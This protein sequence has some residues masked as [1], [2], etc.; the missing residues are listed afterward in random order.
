MKKLKKYIIVGQLLILL[1]VVFVVVLSRSN[2]SKKAYRSKANEPTISPVY[3]MTSPPGTELTFFPGD[4]YQFQPPEYNVMVFTKQKGHDVI[5]KATQDGSDP[6]NVIIKPTPDPLTSAT[7][8]V[9]CSQYLTTCAL[10]ITLKNSGTI[11]AVASIDGVVKPIATASY[12]K[13]PDVVNVVADPVFDP[14]SGSEFYSGLSVRVQTITTGATYKYTFDGSDP[15]TNPLAIISDFSATGLLVINI[16]E[17]STI[18][19]RAYRENMTK[20]NPVTASFRKTVNDNNPGGGGTLT[21]QIR[22]QP[23]AQIAVAGKTATFTVVV[24]ENSEMPITYIWQ[25][26]GSNVFEET[27]NNFFSSYITPK[28]TVEKDNG[29]HYEV[30]IK[31]SSFMNGGIR[32]LQGQLIVLTGNQYSPPTFNPPSGTKFS[33]SQTVTII[34]PESGAVIYYTTD[35]TTPFWGS[36]VYTAP[37]QIYQSA[38]VRAIAQKEGVSQS[39]EATAVYDNGINTGLHTENPDA[40]LFQPGHGVQFSD[41]MIVTIHTPQTRMEIYYTMESGTVPSNSSLKYTSPLILTKPVDITAV[42]YDRARHRYSNYSHALFPSHPGVS[43]CSAPVFSPLSGTEFYTNLSVAITT[44]TSNAAIRYTKDGSEPNVNSPLYSES[45]NL[46]ATTTLKAKCFR[47]D[48]TPS[49]AETATYIRSGLPQVEITDPPNN[50]SRNLPVQIVATVPSQVAKVEL[51]NMY[52][53]VGDFTKQTNT[54]YIYNF[55][56]S[57]IYSMGLKAK[58]I[59]GNGISNFSLPINIIVTGG[60][61]SSSSSSSRSSSSSSIASS[62]SSSSSRP[63]SSSSSR[64]TCEKTKGDANCDGKIDLTDYSIWLLEFKGKCG[65]GAVINADRCQDDGEVPE[66]K[67]GILMD[68]DFNN[69]NGV[70]LADYSNWYANWPGK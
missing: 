11:K 30:F 3:P 18:T 52:G 26:G 41:N 7:T 16:T 50:S 24:T 53:Y 38:I 49:Q 36:P 2:S 68:A 8:A 28:L 39:T 9:T 12:I 62:S 15:D 23:T 64:V 70:T 58:A 55:T 25:R 51:Y 47:A 46:N 43:I 13:L 57:Q 14:P 6:N 31:G 42:V 60:G 54:S 5:I 69:L 10:R 32:S 20:S 44:T 37:F 19:I 22:I 59:N 29:V 35:G 66:Y 27:T 67:D 17:T 63:A 21:G 61:D 56:N 34:P 33:T 4:G 45:L 1:A 65:V 40:P 48:L